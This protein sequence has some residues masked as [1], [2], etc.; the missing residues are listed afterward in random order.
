[1]AGDPLTAP[2]DE[3]H[4]YFAYG[5]NLDPDRMGDRCPGA[6]DRRPGRLRG[7]A[8][9]FNKL[10]LERDG[11]GYANVEPAGADDV[12]EGA[13][14][15]LTKTDLL[16]LDRVEGYPAHYTRRLL[17][18]EEADGTRVAAWVY[19]ATPDWRI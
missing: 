17:A 11:T 13:L 2:D 6:H 15:T 5:S 1:M 14:Y 16:R 4:A 18:V 8:L 3:V 10:S 9:H 7:H 12:V 19:L